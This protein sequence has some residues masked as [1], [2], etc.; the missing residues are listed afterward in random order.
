VCDSEVKDDVEEYECEGGN[1][2]ANGNHWGSWDVCICIDNGDLDN[3][4]TSA[5]MQGDSVYVEE[6]G[7]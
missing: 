4:C 3:Q 6:R 2:E 5:V 7:I 1:L